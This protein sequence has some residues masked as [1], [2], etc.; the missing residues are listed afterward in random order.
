MNNRAIKKLLSVVLCLALLVSTLCSSLISASAATTGTYSIVGDAA[1]AGQKTVTME[2]TLTGD[3]LTSGT[4]DLMFGKDVIDDV[5]FD[6]NGN[7]VAPTNE[8]LEEFY[9]R[10][11]DGNKMIAGVNY[12]KTEEYQSPIYDAEGEITGYETK[13]R[14]V[15]DADK[16]Y[17]ENSSN[18]GTLLPNVYDGKVGL[19]DTKIEITG[20]TLANGT[21]VDSDA[22]NSYF[23]NSEYNQLEGT[24]TN[25]ITGEAADGR[26][27][28]Y[29]M[30]DVYKTAH[31]SKYTTTAITETAADGTESTRHVYELTDGLLDKYYREYTTV[32]VATANLGYSI[33]TVS[34]DG[35]GQTHSYAQY[36]QGFKNITFNA[37]EAFSSIT[38]TVTFD[39]TGT[40]D[41]I[42]ANASVTAGD[43]TGTT[44]VNDATFNYR[45]KD[46]HWATENYVQYGTKYAL[47]FVGGTN[48]SGLTATTD[49][50][51][52][53]YFHVHDG[54]IENG[55]GEA[56]INQAAIDALLAKNPDAKEGVDYFELYN[57][58][59]QKCNRVTPM[60]AAPG[61]PYKV[62]VYD[63]A[64]N[65]TGTTS[66]TTT[67]GTYTYNN[68]RNIS[69]ANVTYEDDGTLSL[70]LHYPSKMDGEQMF[71]TDENGMILSYS[72]IL[73][74]KN[75]TTSV[76]TA[77]ASSKA[78]EKLTEDVTDTATGEVTQKEIARYNDGIL[79]TAQMIS[80][81]GFSAA[82]IDK[83]LYV[84]RYTPR[85]STETQLMGITHS[86]SITQYLNEVVKGTE[87]D[88]A[89]KLV[90]AAFINYANAAT[91]ALG[92]PMDEDVKVIPTEIDLLEFGSYLTDMGSESP[93]YDSIL[94]DNGETGDSWDDPI[95]IDSAEEF[96]YL[97]KKCGGGAVTAGKY[98][99]VADHIAGFDLSDGTLDFDGTLADNLDIIKNG[100]KN[101]SGDTTGFQ[102]NF[103][104]NGVTVYGAVIN[105][106]TYAGVFP[107]VKNSVTIKNLNVKLCYLR[108]TYA[109]GIV[110]YHAA[111]VIAYEKG[112][113][114]HS[115]TIENCSVTDTYLECSSTAWGAG[116]GAIIGRGNAA[117]SWKEADK[118]V[119]GNG[120]GDMVDT[121]Y[122]NTPYDVKNC[123]VNLED[124]YFISTSASTNQVTRG[125]IVGACG[126]NDLSA[127]NCVVI[128]VTPYATNQSASDNQV[129]HAGLETHFS[130]I[131][132]DT[133]SLQ[134]TIGG[135]LGTRNFTGKIFIL[136]EDQMTGEAAKTNMP[137][138][139]WDTIWCAND[140][141]YPSLYAP[142]NI[143]EV[144]PKTIYWDGTTSSS[145]SEGSGTKDDPYI[146][147]TVSELAY[148]VSQAPDKYTVTDGKYFKVADSIANMVLQKEAHAAVMELDS[149][150]ETKSYFESATGL[151]TWKVGGWEGSTFCGNIDFNGVTVYG[152]YIK[153]SGSNAALFCNVDAGA[154]IQNLTLKNSYFTSAASN[155]QVAAVA[156]VSNS[157]NYAKKMAGVTW[158]NRVTIANNYL[159]NTSTQTNR[160]GVL[161]GSF[162][163][164]VY[165]DNLFVYGNDATYGDGVK[166]PL[167]NNAGNSVPETATYVPDGLETKIDITDGGNF[168]FNM[169]RNS[170]ILGC[171]PYDTTQGTG[172]RFN[173]ARAFENV[174]TDAET[175]NVQFTNEKKTF[176]PAQLTRISADDIK[177]LDAKVNMPQLDWYNALTNPDG[178]WH[179]SYVNGMPS[180]DESNDSIL[181]ALEVIAPDQVTAYKN[182][183]FTAD[184]YNSAAEVYDTVGTKGL[185]FGVYATSLNL[186]ANPY[187]SFTFAFNKEYKAARDDIK[188]TVTTTKNTYELP[189]MPA[190]GADGSDVFFKQD[191]W[192]HNATSGRYHLYRLTGISMSELVNDITITAYDPVKGETV[193]L[194]KFDA[195]GFGYELV[196]ANNAMPC[197]YYETRIEATRALIFYVQAIIN[198][199]GA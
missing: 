96:V 15:V 163:D 58:R 103:D 14:T 41:R 177:G 38:F 73:E 62:D 64:G 128:G 195:S 135:T 180:L 82:D 77:T 42:G 131:Y 45:N 146:I 5:N 139:N 155:Y 9:A 189:A 102:G 142:Y 116:V 29:N 11:T 109:G 188:I 132:T 120:D 36:A 156:A 141:D 191:G 107:Y 152:A 44:T 61:L 76:F 26:Q 59:C 144:E 108:G 127:N 21:V 129:Q 54:T 147:N 72:D 6:A 50:A 133:G 22:V 138:L 179:C 16:S 35:V 67:K 70:N 92:T 192:T 190:T 60:I 173:D 149:A 95:I 150:A 137:N 174:Y 28:A 143:P 71:I 37:S 53:N 198:R 175:T 171:D 98:Y 97:S 85:S 79:S 51:S 40:C 197:D 52:T 66:A 119:D 65:K 159:Y 113:A 93:Y 106:S 161:V 115:V 136:T 158:I 121:I 87:Y 196:E 110:G 170:I 172:S 86:I 75:D 134:T 34:E 94:A 187:I 32:D 114:M 23:T 104:G 122:V 167:I 10:D 194:G 169:V 7:Y 112:A 101:H 25:A 105:G 123:Y 24:T 83:K 125:G 17:K 4:F 117:P 3:S 145:I 12:Y 1:G 140:G 49:T 84:A 89:D 46:G 164:A 13:T 183:E 43:L 55:D 130:N 88:E 166:M 199:Y 48:L 157:I 30:T 162:S 181:D 91:T 99:K 81:K 90:A 148:V 124:Q 27:F 151:L 69:G 18:K 186:K 57:A 39:F 193:E 19:Y 176:T 168:H 160:S 185:N 80:V 8:T 118:K 154:A 31:T 111:D 2:V 182:M 165:A 63:E 33:S 47:N 74:N 78:G 56:P 126:S 100:G 68:Y 20:G 153:D 178:A 184:V